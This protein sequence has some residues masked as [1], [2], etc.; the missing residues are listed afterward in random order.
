[1]NLA[2]SISQVICPLFNIRKSPSSSAHSET[3]K[4][5]NH[6]TL[7]RN[8]KEPLKS[9]HTG[10]IRDVNTILVIQN[11][12]RGTFLISKN[13]F[14]WL[15]IPLS[16][17][18]YVI[19]NLFSCLLASG[20]RLAQTLLIK[21]R[22]HP[23]PICSA[24]YIVPTLCQY[25]WL[26]CTHPSYMCSYAVLSTNTMNPPMLICSGIFY[27]HSANIRV[28]DMMQWT[29]FSYMINCLSWLRSTHRLYDQHW[30]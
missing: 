3:R 16:T 7:S 30:S 9:N 11:P 15:L 20:V 24:G 23:Q 1:M 12:K 19:W 2:N 29:I 22:T 21:P 25:A 14:P 28:H 27:Q 13:R 8:P 26:Y 5:L 17:N 4:L 18:K 6:K 10:V